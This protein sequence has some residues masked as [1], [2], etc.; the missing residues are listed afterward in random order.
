MNRSLYKI[1]AKIMSADEAKHGF[2]Y[3][4]QFPDSEPLSDEQT[5]RGTTLVKIG[6]SGDTA[7]R[8]ARWRSQCKYTPCVVLDLKT[9]HM[10]R[11]EKIIQGECTLLSFFRFY[12]LFATISPPKTCCYP[13]FRRESLPCSL[14]LFPYSSLHDR[15]LTTYC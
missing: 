9:P 3:G 1:I 10:G 7:T 2:I 11:C 12:I 15:K 4:Y 6:K 14:F 8:M 13:L 5:P